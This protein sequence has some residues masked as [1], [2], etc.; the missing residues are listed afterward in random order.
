MKNYHYKYLISI[1]ITIVFFHFIL[2]NNQKNHILVTI[3][4]TSILFSLYHF[5]IFFKNLANSNTTSSLISI[6]IT[7]FYINI[8][9]KINYQYYNFIVSVLLILIGLILLKKLNRNKHSL[10]FL[11]LIAVNT[12]LLFTSDT[13]LFKSKMKGIDFWNS[14]ITWKSF[15]GVPINKSKF[16]AYIVTE[17]RGLE[18]KVYNYP[19]AILISILKPFESWRKKLKDT[20]FNHLLLEHE[21]RHFDITEIYKIKALDSVK[22]SWGKNSKDIKKIINFFNKKEDEYQKHYDSITNHGL[23][24]INQNKMNIKI[25]NQLK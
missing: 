5:I 16:D 14:K 6:F 24:T 8:I 22:K 18:N 12:G 19:P 20:T 11:I 4:F 10:I 15:K 17:F 3:G 13:W 7:L 25:L 21:Q 23:D 2:L 1:F 9:L